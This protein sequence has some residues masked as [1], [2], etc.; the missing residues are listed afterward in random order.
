[1]TIEQESII[2]FHKKNGEDLENSFANLLD[3]TRYAIPGE[4]YIDEKIAW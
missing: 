1:M 4:I 3:Y 2:R